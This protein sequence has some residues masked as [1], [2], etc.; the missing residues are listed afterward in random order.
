MFKELL[1]R[2]EI[3]PLEENDLYQV[4]SVDIKGHPATLEDYLVQS[5]PSEVL[6]SFGI[7][8]G[9]ATALAKKHDR[10]RSVRSLSD[11]ELRPVVEAYLESVPEDETLEILGQGSFS[12]NELRQEIKKH[13]AVGERITEIVRQHNIFLEEA[14]KQGKV[15]R[16]NEE[17]GV[18][19][20]AFDF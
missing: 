3:V 10:V 17:T 13:T 11:T 7:E 20:P 1:D 19:L 16:K 18:R 15:Q 8:P 2:M 14:I 6:T 12:K 5:A 9:T 4:F